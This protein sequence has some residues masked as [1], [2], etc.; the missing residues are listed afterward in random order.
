MKNKPR[1]R[2][3]IGVLLSRPDVKQWVCSD[4]LAYGFGG[5][6]LEAYLWWKVAKRRIEDA[7]R[8]QG[9]I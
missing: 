5:T 8:G 2:R 7:I 3:S 1:I 4:S 9:F 6:P